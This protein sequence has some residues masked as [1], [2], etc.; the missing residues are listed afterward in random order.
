MS[1]FSTL[2]LRSKVLL[3]VTT[4][5]LVGFSITIGVLTYKAAN[6][7]QAS[8]LEYTRAL[9]RQHANEVKAEIDSAF[10]AARTLAQSLEGLH[11][12]GLSNRKLA[13][14]MLKSVLEG[15]PAFIGVWTI[16]EPNAFDGKDNAYI[17][18]TG[19]DA[20]GRYLPY[21]NRPNGVTEVTALTDY[22]TPGPGDYY[23]LARNSGN[24]TLLEPYAYEI[25][26][27]KVLI[28]SMA[29][30]IYKNG[31]VVGVAGVD[32]LLSEFQQK[33]S[34]IKPFDTGFA[35]LLSNQSIYVGD[36]D[37][38]N[39]GKPMA[40]GGTGDKIRQAI[41]QGQAYHDSIKDPI[42]QTDILRI[43][44]PIQIAHSKT[45]WSFAIAVPEDKILSGVHKLRNTAIMIGLLSIILVSLALGYL[46]DR[47]VIR[48]IGGEPAEAAD[49]AHHIAEG[50]L[51]T[52]VDLKSGDQSSMLH[53]MKV[54]QDQLR[55]IVSEIRASSEYVSNASSEIALGNSDLSQRTENQAA[56]LEQTAASIEELTST[57]GQN[58]EN[59]RTANSLA[60]TAS[61]T[62][63]KASSTVSGAVST[64][65]QI[66][67]QSQKMSEITAVIE[68]IAFQTNILALNAAVEAARAGEQGRGFAVVAQEVRNL[69]QRSAS[70][71][72][73][74]KQLID[75][76]VTKIGQGS[77][78]VI[79]AGNTMQE[80]VAAVQ[81]VSSIMS[82]I[83]HASEEQS[84]GIQQINIAITS[85]DEVTQQNAALVEEA[86]AAAQSL[87]DQAQQLNKAVSVFRLDQS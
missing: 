34:K 5:I 26:G 57:V 38:S 61:T 84:T 15:N 27:K 28:T 53:A 19:S 68:G 55:S 67:N 30:P 36:R 41:Q 65:T 52:R 63:E 77:S 42:L 87:D 75:E 73:E 76:S 21:W 29:V 79:D 44:Q 70:A 6:L 12:A 24:E 80:V 43:Y 60:F 1:S 11:A 20:T 7:Q 40:T 4:L 9:S 25:G 83:V 14:S 47:M 64:M 69:A 86:M 74:I 59:A 72:K 35:S 66:S 23:L 18:Q 2:T 13:D 78:Q 54:M 10:D 81:R 33:I 39:V 48:P 17:N 71:A 50:N 56:S 8:A 22:T 31:T 3:I 82:E 37:A 58:T 62:A 46:I 51:S 85:M 45:P 32:I 16:W 49:L